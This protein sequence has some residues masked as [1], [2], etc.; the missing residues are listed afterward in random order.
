MAKYIDLSSVV[1]VEP[2]VCEVLPLI[3][4]DDLQYEFWQRLDEGLIIAEIELPSEDT[5]FD[6]PQW[7]GKEV[8]QDTTYYNSTLSKT[9][10]KAIQKSYA[11]AKAWDDWRDSLVKG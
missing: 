2:E 6:K 8:T 3:E 1:D 9:S 10:W 7:L 5:Q 11:E 4:D